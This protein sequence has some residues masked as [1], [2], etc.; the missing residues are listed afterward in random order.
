MAAGEAVRV[1][2]MIDAKTLA[3]YGADL[4]KKAEAGLFTAYVGGD[5]EATLSVDF[6][7]AES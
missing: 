5:S 1:S 7:L 4:Q 3:F 6:E 2:F